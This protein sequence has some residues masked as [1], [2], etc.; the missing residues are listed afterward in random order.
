MRALCTMSTLGSSVLDAPIVAPYRPSTDYISDDLRFVKITPWL[1]PLPI[2][3]ASEAAPIRFAPSAQARLLPACSIC[4]PTSVRARN[5]LAQRVCSPVWRRIIDALA[6]PQMHLP[7]HRLSACLIAAFTRI[8]PS[9][10]GG[11]ERTFDR[12]PVGTHG[13][14][15]SAPDRLLLRSSRASEPSSCSDKSSLP[16][17]ASTRMPTALGA[18]RAGRELLALARA[19]LIDDASGHAR[20]LFLPE[21]EPSFCVVRSMPATSPYAVQHAPPCL[22]DGLIWPK[23]GC[24]STV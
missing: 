18:E 16:Q 14:V 6:T 19:S 21:N 8:R 17:S 7:E 3:P 20:T 13:L 15:T 11:V 2:S 10:R 12:A 9:T 23:T 1:R 24:A 5:P 4:E 22:F